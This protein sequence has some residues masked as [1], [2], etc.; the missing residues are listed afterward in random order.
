MHEK[1]IGAVFSDLESGQCISD[2]R[3]PLRIPGL[4]RKT[5]PIISICEGGKKIP[6]IVSPGQNAIPSARNRRES[7]THSCVRA[8]D[9]TRKPR[10][11]CVRVRTGLIRFIVRTRTGPPR[12]STITADRPCDRRARDNDTVY[13]LSGIIRDRI[14]YTFV[15]ERTT[16][17]KVTLE[18]SRERFLYRSSHTGPRSTNTSPFFYLISI[19]ST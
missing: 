8:L 19:R 17:I 11:H 13:F 10:S 1:C 16:Q 4:L 5:S 15:G 9:K 18:M 12:Q 2:I 7:K 6:T 3:R 14:S